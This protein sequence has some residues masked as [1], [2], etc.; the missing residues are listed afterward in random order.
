MPQSR[1]SLWLRWSSFALLLNAAYLAAFATPS[2]FYFTNVGLHPVLGLLVAAQ[3][4]G[5]RKSN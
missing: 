3:P 2:L 5:S 4:G 1:L